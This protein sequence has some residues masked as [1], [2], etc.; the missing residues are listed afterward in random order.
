MKFAAA[1]VLIFSLQGVPAGASLTLDEA[2]RLALQKNERFKISEEDVAA[3]QQNIRLA[4]SNVLPTVSTSLSQS[5]NKQA[6][7]GGFLTFKNNTDLRLDVHQ[8][9]YGGGKEWAA[10]RA[11]KIQKEISELQI[12]L[13]RQ[14]VLF[15]VA[16]EY[17]ALLRAQEK[18]TISRRA[19][20]LARDQ[21]ALAK[22]RKEAGT[23]T[24]TEVIRSEVSASTAARDLVRSEND[25]SVYR[26]RLGFVIGQPVDAPVSPVSESGADG[27]GA[28]ASSV[29]QHVRQA[30]RNRPDYLISELVLKVAEEGL[31]AERAGFFPSAG[32]A[33]SYSH[34]AHVSSFRDPDNWQVQAKLEYDLFE[35]FGRNAEYAKAKTDVRQAALEQMQLSRQIELDVQESLL[36]L[37]ALAAI[38]DASRQEV[39]SARENYER[40]IAQF[41]EGLS[42][43]VDVA[44]AHTAMIAAEVELA[45]A[46]SDIG[47]A[48]RK[49]EWATGTLG[50][51]ATR[52]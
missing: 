6:G 41:R 7:S 34:T 33:G 9:L 28:D 40:V 25:V 45:T 23:A 49:L 1:A 32:I 12:K 38:R 52:P 39:G 13:V 22:A 17:F 50:D 27:T 4:R 10:Y 30:V 42:T 24:R 48:R 36:A 26:A 47:L 46:S 20:D 18:L 19:L 11:A 16:A 31:R 15:D 3:A 14:S 35:G 8:P 43:A 29:E 44:D 37:E 2:F 21:L 51:G 5:R